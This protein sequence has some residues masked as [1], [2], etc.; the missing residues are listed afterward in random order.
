MNRAPILTDQPP[1][2]EHQDATTARNPDHP[3]RL[4]AEDAFKAT[5]RRIVTQL[6]IEATMWQ[7]LGKDVP[8]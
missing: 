5:A 6:D 1:R 3:E 2:P 7:M 4:K 8:Y